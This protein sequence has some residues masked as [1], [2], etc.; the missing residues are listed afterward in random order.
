MPLTM[1]LRSHGFFRG[2]LKG[3][4]RGGSRQ[5]R[6]LLWS[7]R[8]DQGE[9]GPLARDRMDRTPSDC[10]RYHERHTR[11]A[12]QK[13]VCVWSVTCPNTAQLSPLHLHVCVDFLERV[14]GH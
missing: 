12:R 1:R 5:L 13:A 14:G 7:L 6:S 4:R 9:H 8:R 3:Q 2:C 11:R 10:H